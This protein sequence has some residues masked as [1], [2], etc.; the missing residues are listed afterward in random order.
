MC[1]VRRGQGQSMGGGRKGDRE[2]GREGG[3]RQQ[4][5]ASREGRKTHELWPAK[6]LNER[7]ERKE[8]QLENKEWEVKYRSWTCSRELTSEGVCKD[9]KLQRRRQAW[10]KRRWWVEMSTNSEKELYATITMNTGTD[11]RKR[12]PWTGP[13]RRVP[14]LC[15]VSTPIKW[16]RTNQ[17]EMEKFMNLKIHKLYST[18]FGKGMC[19]KIG[20]QKK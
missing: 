13:P 19:K 7:K 8:A 3:G 16:A 14:K 5:S 1:G 20:K 15:Q 11:K 9:T 10:E 18:G 6:M 2:K 4:P 17:R 12:G